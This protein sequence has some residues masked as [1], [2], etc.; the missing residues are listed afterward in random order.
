MTAITV[1]DGQPFVSGTLY[2]NNKLLRFERLLIDTGSERCVFKTEDLESI[3]VFSAPDD[4]VFLIIG[5]GGTETVIEKQIEGLEIGNLILRPFKIELGALD[6]GF[7]IDGII[8]VDFLRQAGALLD[9][10][11]LELRPAP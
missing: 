7:E 3:G 4:E 11:A 9:A 10:K 5:V 8:G 2:A 1:I 6:Y